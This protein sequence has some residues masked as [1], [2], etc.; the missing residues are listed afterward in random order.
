M[1]NIHSY[2][3]EIE[4][5]LNTFPLTISSESKI[6]RIDTYKGYLKT[7]TTFVD[8]SELHLFHFTEIENHGPV[9]EKYRY[10]YQDKNGE[11]IKRWDNAKHHPDLD[12]FPDHVHVG[13]K[14]KGSDRP[15]IEGL[16]E[17]IAHHIREVSPTFHDY[18]E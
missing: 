3:L 17:D 14:V 2:F 11:L 5:T 16:L 1:K 9:I 18:E 10:H 7:K 12:T 8:G 6:E 15:D 13:G 4:D